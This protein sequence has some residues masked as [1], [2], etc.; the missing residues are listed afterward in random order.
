[1][2]K[3]LLCLFALLLSVTA[4]NAQKVVV[5][6]KAP[7]N[8]VVK[9]EGVRTP[10]MLKA[11]AAPN[12][13]P[14]EDNER[15]MGFYT[16]DDLDYNY[17][18]ALT[19]PGSYQ[20]GVEFTSDVI[21]LFVG[22]Q[23][24]KVRFGLGS[25][26][27]ASKVRIYPVDLEENLIL[28]AVAEVDVPSTVQGWNDV[29][30]PNPVTIEP[31]FDYI[32][33]YEYEEKGD[34][35][36]PLLVDGS[37]NSTGGM[38]GGFLGYGD[39]NGNGEIGWYDLGASYGNLCIQAVVKGGSFIDDDITLDGIAV[40]K[41]FLKQ[42]EDNEIN[43]S[44]GIKNTGNNIPDSYEL[45]LSIDGK[46][47]ASIRDL[48]PLTNAT[49][50]LST[51]FPV[52]SDLSV[53]K[54]TFTLSVTA[55]NGAAPTQNVEDDQVSVEFGYYSESVPRQMNLV[56]QFTSTNCGFCPLGT[57]VLTELQNMRDD[58]IW[59]SLHCSG[60]DYGHP[61]PDPFTT[62]ESDVIG[63]MMT[64]G[65]PT[66][67]FN[68][69][70]V[71]D[72]SLNQDGTLAMGLGYSSEYSAVA[73]EQIFSP[74]IDLSNANIP[75]FATVDIATDYDEATREL[76]VTVS[77][78]TVAGFKELVGEDAGLTVYLTED[79]LV[80][81]QL[82]YVTNM[83][84]QTTSQNLDDYVH[85]HVLRDVVS[86]NVL[87]GDPI[88]M[89][90]ETSYSNTYTVTID[91]SWNPENMHV[92]AFIGRP[93]SSTSYIDDMWVNNANMVKLGESGTVGISGVE[94]TGEDVKEV[95]RY[96]IDGAKISAPVKGINVIKMS[97]GTTRK[98]IVK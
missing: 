26:V 1:M 36:Y 38:P 48:V 31:N 35:S 29:T 88:S 37:V 91:G 81:T 82:E 13:I 63:G 98:V 67:T 76:S 83:F 9:K 64:T 2:K 32:I 69:Y 12:K 10:N 33:S 40:E 17:A 21:G 7:A 39:F 54:H 53:G 79:N 92:V 95:G 71:S 42:G 24:T 44:F 3:T 14:L 60:M 20:V 47:Q 6:K 43:F 86:E 56:E 15:I 16:S 25:S 96:S 46:L 30:L 41:P 72:P 89:T 70:F 73:A 49:Q 27:G 19:V 28:E 90:G 50:Y 58:V 4:V 93:V 34:D 78:N 74:V 45:S 5:G 51:S 80:A 84:G 57:A 77:G 18:L 65:Y 11:P 97:D 66:A 61:T 55:I 8:V 85:N 68:R 94:T 62:D 52:P 22:G 87:G 59:V 75:S 23:I